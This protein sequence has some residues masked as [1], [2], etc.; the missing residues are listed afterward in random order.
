MVSNKEAGASLHRGCGG[1]GGMCVAGCCNWVDLGTVFREHLD[2][3]PRLLDLA[4][5]SL[6]LPSIYVACPPPALR[7]CPPRP[8]S[9]PCIPARLPRVPLAGVEHLGYDLHHHGY[10]EG[11]TPGC[12]APCNT[13]EATL[14][15][16]GLRR[17][18]SGWRREGGG[19]ARQRWQAR[20]G[21]QA[22]KG[23]RTPPCGVIRSVA[24]R[25]EEGEW[26]RIR[27]SKSIASSRNA[28]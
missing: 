3:C 5:Y 8:P 23:M 17:P 4:R 1:R 14:R 11:D 9:A 10:G 16:Y 25:G 19:E 18:E 22:E 27:N 21:W 12:A 7:A 15:S 13:S 28:P 6:P 26:V 24:W 2:I 20:Q